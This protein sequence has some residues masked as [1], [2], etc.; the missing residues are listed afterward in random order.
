MRRSSTLWVHRRSLLTARSAL[1]STTRSAL[2]LTA[3]VAVAGV[4]LVVLPV[5]WGCV[6]LGEHR[7]VVSAH[8]A[9]K[10]ALERRIFDL[11]RS[12]KSLDTERVELLERV[13]DLR[14]AHSTLQ[15]DIAKLEK[16]RE[17]LTQHL[18][19]RDAQV[20]E[21]SKLKGTY[22]GLVSD[23]ESEVSAGQI[24][25]EQLRDGI[26]MNLPQDILFPS[27]S[28]R[29][30]PRGTTVLRKV[31]GR[32]A[33]LTHIIEVHGHTDDVPLSARLASRFGS[34]W[35]LAGARAASVVRLLESE[36]VDPGRMSSVSRGQWAPVDSNDTAVGRA[37]N[38]RIEIRLIPLDAPVETE[39]AP[40]TPTGGPAAIPPAP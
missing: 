1:L 32:L 33:K 29:L 40:A 37:R 31:S 17:L 35:E 23:L 7:A 11:E 5:L 26:R 19:E 20:T 3:R 14:E 28:V 10:A 39:P 15:T 25:I 36:G 22:E 24:Q 9:D 13:E 2:L 21:L 16:T 6:S 38:R 12:N 4:C 30:D 18:R 8:E 34:N 27:G